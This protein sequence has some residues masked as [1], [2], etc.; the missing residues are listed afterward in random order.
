MDRSILQDFEREDDGCVL[1][2]YPSA[3]VLNR[4]GG[5]VA[6]LIAIPRYT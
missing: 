1:N 6:E 2:S 3:W 4:T 5:N